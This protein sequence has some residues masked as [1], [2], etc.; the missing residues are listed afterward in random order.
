VLLGV[1]VAATTKVDEDVDD[2]PRGRCCWEFWQWPPP[3]LMKMSIAPPWEV[4]LGA[5]TAI[6][7]E[8]DEDING[9]PPGRCYRE[10]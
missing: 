4:L 6:T 8:V 2:G 1:S 3:K 9:A 10:L 5:P 7:T